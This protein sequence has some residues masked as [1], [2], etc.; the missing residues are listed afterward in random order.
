MQGRC[1]RRARSSGRSVVACAR[2]AQ[3]ILVTAVLVLLPQIASAQGSPW[4]RAAGNLERTFTAGIVFGGGLAL[5]AAQFLV[6]LF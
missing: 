3:I 2:R 4:E 6:W 1:L 5:F